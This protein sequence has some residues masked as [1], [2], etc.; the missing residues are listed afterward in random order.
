MADTKVQSIELKQTVTNNP[1]QQYRQV[2][3]TTCY[4]KIARGAGKKT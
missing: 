3:V 4:L 1:R 2:C